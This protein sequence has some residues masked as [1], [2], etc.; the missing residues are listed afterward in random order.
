MSLSQLISCEQNKIRSIKN[1]SLT[2][3]ALLNELDTSNIKLNE[4]AHQIIN[5]E[6]FKPDQLAPSIT[7]IECSLSDLGLTG[8]GNFNQINA[9]IIKFNLSYCPIEFAPFIR[10]A[11][12]EQTE[13][14]V[15]TVNQNPHGAITIFS[16]TLS[17]D[18]DFP[19]G[20]YLRNFE[21]SNWL[22]GYCCSNDYLWA[23]DAR[24]IF[25]VKQPDR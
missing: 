1:A 2:K 16:E 5:S 24:M 8:G 13:S 25:Q 11:Y 3:L 18:E 22:R 7:I 21:G 14:K 20:L 6:R 4:Y 23:S 10:L 17:E 9:A 15:N 12:L 19:R